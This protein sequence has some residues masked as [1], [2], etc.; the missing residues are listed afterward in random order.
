MRFPPWCVDFVS[1]DRGTIEIRGWAIPADQRSGPASFSINGRPFDSTTYPIERPDI[2]NLF[3][4]A[5]DARLSGFLCRTRI[6]ESD[7]DEYRFDYLDLQTGKPFY[8]LHAY[9]HT[10]APDRFPLPEP[11]R[12]ARVH[13]GSDEGAFRLEG[14]STYKKFEAILQQQFGRRYTD[15][16]AILDWG[17]G[18]SRVLRHFKPDPMQTVTGI[19]IDADN[20]AWCAANIP[21]GRFHHIDLM[22][23]TP[24]ADASFDLMIGV[25]VFTHLSE[26]DQH[27]WLRELARIAK[28]GAILLMTTHGAFTI[29]RS[30]QS[31]AAFAT[32][33]QSGFMDGG[34]NHDLGDQIKNSA[35]YY[36][37]V[38]HTE[39][40][41]NKNWSRY[42]KVMAIVPG[43][44][45]NHQ[46]VVVLQ[47]Q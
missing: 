43:V 32:W 12:R 33:V 30:G 15:F 18:C 4:F 25:S 17:C 1:I 46:D 2:G 11:F 14:L 31:E 27:L 7:R 34:G 22:P 3:W 24:L 6:L 21:F 36:R 37:N 42:F 5:D 16:P 29:C 8:D 28:P 38:F 10:T 39:K 35:D 19:D 47:K 9:H 44:V 40:Y 45:G 26:A 13:G 23:P 20:V 41:I